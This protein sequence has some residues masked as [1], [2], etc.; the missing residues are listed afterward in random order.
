[1]GVNVT[2]EVDTSELDAAAAKFER[3]V[4][5]GT[6]VAVAV[7]CDEGAALIKRTHRYKDRTGELTDKIR[8]VRPT[9]LPGGGAEG[10]I[11]ALAKHSSYVEEDTRA[12]EIRPKAA[13]SFIGPLHPSQTRRRDKGPAKPMLVFQINGRW[14]S[15][16]VVHHPGTKGKGFMGEAAIVAERVLIREVEVVIDTAAKP[17]R[18]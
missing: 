18:G 1:M 17:L 4:S 12:H 16:E 7:A 3:D 10:E 5:A 8:S 6:R 11:V 13:K 9:N 15:K 14:V 2:C